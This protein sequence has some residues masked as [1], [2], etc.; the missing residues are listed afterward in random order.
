MEFAIGLFGSSLC[1]HQIKA[2]VRPESE[3]NCTQSAADFLQNDW[4]CSL[5]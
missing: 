3:L 2:L 4:S 5:L 1:I